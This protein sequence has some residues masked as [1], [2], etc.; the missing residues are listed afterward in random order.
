MKKIIKDIC[1]CLFILIAVI[2]YVVIA[3]EIAI[4]FMDA[5]G[6]GIGDVTKAE[7]FFK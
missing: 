5:V 4:R 6:L 3:H 1:A 7:T 2:V